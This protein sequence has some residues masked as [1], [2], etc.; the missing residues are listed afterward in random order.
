MTASSD[1]EKESLDIEAILA[2]DEKSELKNLDLAFRR[3]VLEGL[4]KD[5]EAN[6][7]LVLE[8]PVGSPLETVRKRYHELSQELHPDR[9]F[10]KELGHYKRRLESLF[11]RIQKAYARLKD[12]FDKEAIDKVLKMKEAAS[13]PPKT[14]PSRTRF[15]EVS[16]ITHKPQVPKE[17]SKNL[18]KFA[19]SETAYKK[20]LECEKNRKFFDAYKYFVES[21][22][23]EPKRDLYIAAHQRIQVAAF[24]ERAQKQIEELKNEVSAMGFSM[25]ALRRAEDLMR[26]DPESLDIK[27]IFC[28]A[29]VEKKVEDRYPEVMTL[30]QRLKGVRQHDAEPYYLLAKVY[31][32]K[33]DK[34]A[35]LKEA[36]EALQKN[37][38]YAPAQKLIERLK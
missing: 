27:F 9:H 38:A 37:P 23:L 5:Y 26:Q 1:E 21:L 2:D 19:K 8:L 4:T 32:A 14:R 15:N 22:K 12:P 11:S 28:K 29:I 7:Y 18:E 34:K 25:A 31:E 17:V 36:K 35:A 6:P 20:G 33:E 10:K 16:V 30:L 24:R 3:R 13:A